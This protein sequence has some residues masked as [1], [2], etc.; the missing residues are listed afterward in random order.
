MYAGNSFPHAGLWASN[1]SRPSSVCEKLTEASER[2]DSE[3][4]FSGGTAKIKVKNSASP[5][6]AMMITRVKLPN[7]SAIKPEEYNSIVTGRRLEQGND[8]HA[9]SA[10]R[11]IIYATFLFSFPI[12]FLAY[13][14]VRM[15]MLMVQLL[16]NLYNFKL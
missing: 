2:V 16:D 14:L 5:T 4:Q 11:L 7:L 6:R 1:L 10:I 9:S 8:T 12:L 15:L 13:L 3:T